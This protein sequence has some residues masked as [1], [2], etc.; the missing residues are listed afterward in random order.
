MAG[1]DGKAPENLED[2]MA[3]LDEAAGDIEDALREVEIDPD[4]E[5][6]D[7]DFDG[8]VARA[9]GL[10]DQFDGKLRRMHAK[11]RAQGK[12]DQMLRGL[13]E[14]RGMAKDEEM[15]F[16]QLAAG[17]GKAPGTGSVD[18]RREGVDD[19]PDGG[20]LAQ[21]KGQH[22]DGPSLSAVESAESGTGVSGRRGEARS[23]E[24]SRQIESFVQRDDIP[25]T[26]KLGVRNYFE[27]LES[28]APRPAE[29]E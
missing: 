15:R 14:A 11:G 17:G 28:A 19:S 8:P 20:G 5:W 18:S 4:A 6:A 25:D 26:L 13:A 29:G 16:Q 3:E 7:G 2:L 21:L 12:L 27:N 9:N 1:A 23:R 10:L 24:F 22:G